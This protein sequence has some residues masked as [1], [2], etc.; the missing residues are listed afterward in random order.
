MITLYALITIYLLIVWYLEE[1]TDFELHIF[2][3]KVIVPALLWIW[4]MVTFIGIG[5]LFITYLP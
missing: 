3:A 5:Y 2:V 4:L 1:K